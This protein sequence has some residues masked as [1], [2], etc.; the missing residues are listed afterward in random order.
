MKIYNI[1]GLQPVKDYIEPS[2]KRNSTILD[3]KGDRVEIS[4]A[5]QDRATKHPLTNIVKEYLKK[6]PSLREDRV[7]SAVQSVKHGY[8]F[9]REKLKIIAE[10]ILQNFNLFE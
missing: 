10:K 5:A 6:A 3:K 4:Y 9:D 8:Q 1:N 7:E 2:R